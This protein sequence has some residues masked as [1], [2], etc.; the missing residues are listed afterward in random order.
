MVTLKA[1]TSEPI[2]T[3]EMTTA[4]RQRVSSTVKVE[5]PLAVPVTFAIGCKV[6]HVSVP[7]YFTVPAQS[8]VGAKLI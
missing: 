3:V 5:N 6:P 7:R 1:T 4:A 2:S 8:Q